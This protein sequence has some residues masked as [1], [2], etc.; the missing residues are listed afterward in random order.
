M[1]IIFI[2][3]MN[4]QHFT[5]ETLKHYWLELLQKGLNASNIAV[6]ADQLN[7]CLPFYGDLLTEHQLSNRLNLGTFLPQSISNWHFP[8][9]FNHSTAIVQ[10]IDPCITALP[11]FNTNHTSTL[12]RRIKTI[13][14]LAKD[15]TLKELMIFLN[16]YPLLHRKLIQKFLVETYLYLANTE[17]MHEVHARILQH[18]HPK[19]EHI[20]VAHSLG[21]VIAYNLLHKMKHF[22]IKRFITLGSPLAFKVIQ[23][24]LS[25]PI[26]RPQQLHGDWFNFYSPDDFLTTFA[27]SEPPFQFNPPIKNTAIQTLMSNP[28]QIAGFLTHPAVVK[29]LMDGISLQNV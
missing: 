17:F 21:T 1:K 2:H 16:H 25:Q 5:A 11:T 13:S 23:A 12:T 7:I 26:S 15:H 14:A 19:E 29:S 24:Q 3:G 28:H 20:I 9:H 27:L 6:D 22:R 10:N 18:M 8:V 4:Q